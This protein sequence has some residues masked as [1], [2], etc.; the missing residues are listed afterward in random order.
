[1]A[2]DYKGSLSQKYILFVT[3]I[4]TATVPGANFSKVMI[5]MDEA[6]AAANFV[7]DPGVDTITELTPQNWSSLLKATGGMWGWINGFYSINSVTHVF[8]V[9]FNDGGAGKFNN[10]DLS[11]QYTLYEERA[12]FKLMYDTINAGS[13]QIAL[14]TLCGAGIGQTA[15]P[16]SQYV[17]GTNDPTTLTGSL[18]VP[19]TQV[20]WFRLANPQ[21]DVPIAY[22]PSTITNAA[23]QQLA[24]TL[25]VVN[26]TGT[27]V[28]N[29]LD[30]LAILPA[31]MT[32][33]GAGGTNVT[34]LQAIALQAQ[35]VAFFTFIGDNS[36]NCALEAWFT[37]ITGSNFG[38]MWIKN[39]IDTVTSQNAATLLTATAQSG[40]K[41]NDTYQQ[42]LNLLQVNINLFASIGRLFPV[43]Q[44]L[45]ASLGMSPIPT[46]FI[47]APPFNLL[48]P[49]SGGVFIVPKAWAALYAQDVTSSIIYGTLVLQA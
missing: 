49:A 2:F 41:N 5:F 45:A 39:Y 40:F 43:P 13:A 21:L 9:T 30:W 34:A 38:A 26:A 11:A 3:T 7:V 6:E 18:A 37:C 44:A 19:G 1:M 47:T 4:L 16:L 32:P 36:G 28:G 46:G 42:L 35:G 17:F 25:A 33:S 22:H 31:M 8:I 20:G 12:Y 15:D 24:A 10:T 27:N 29:K 23:L 48:P 14:A